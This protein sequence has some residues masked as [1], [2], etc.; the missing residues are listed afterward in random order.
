MCVEFAYACVN[1]Q[2]RKS[3]R[4]STEIKMNCHYSEN[5]E[6]VHRYH[7]KWKVFLLHVSILV[8]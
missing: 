7:I 3:I 6:V 5:L 4:Q 2:V 1:D 8:L